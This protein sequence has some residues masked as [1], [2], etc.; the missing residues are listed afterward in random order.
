MKQMSLFVANRVLVNPIPLPPLDTSIDKRGPRASP[1][2]LCG[3][4]VVAVGQPWPR[5]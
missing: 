5:L 2:E 3:P 1:Y 4:P